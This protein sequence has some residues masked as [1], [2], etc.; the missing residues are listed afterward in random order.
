MPRKKK[1]KWEQCF[2][3]K[4]GNCMIMA[5]ISS[6]LTPV[7]K[8]CNPIPECELGLEIN[9]IGSTLS[10]KYESTADEHILRSMGIGPMA[11]YF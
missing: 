3:Y 6:R 4:E 8:K 2:F 5:D 9:R 7:N 1:N 11:N 10:C